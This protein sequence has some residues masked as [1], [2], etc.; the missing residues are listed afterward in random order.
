MP[1][2][3]KQSLERYVIIVSNMYNIMPQKAKKPPIELT[4]AIRHF[5]TELP[6]PI[7]S[8]QSF[9][10]KELLLE[11]KKVTLLAQKIK[12]AKGM[13]WNVNVSEYHS[14]AH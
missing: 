11:N 10:L 12:G 1:Q 5:T 2:L 3:C 6:N 4:E 7:T 9:F 8:M 14:A 13:A